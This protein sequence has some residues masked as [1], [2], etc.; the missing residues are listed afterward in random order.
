MGLCLGAGLILPSF[1]IGGQMAGHLKRGG[2]GQSLEILG[3]ERSGFRQK[4]PA[5]KNARSRLLSAASPA[6]PIVLHA[7]VCGIAGIN[8]GHIQK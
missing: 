4:A 7:K 6:G 1:S 3:K 8:N 5:Q 2:Q